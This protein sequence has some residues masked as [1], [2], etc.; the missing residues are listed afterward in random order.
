MHADGHPVLQQLLMAGQRAR[1]QTMV[2]ALRH[3]GIGRRALLAA[4]AALSIGL[5]QRSTRTAVAWRGPPS[6]TLLVRGETTLTGEAMAWRVVRDVAE[7]HAEAGFERRALG[8]AVATSNFTPLLLTD[9]ATGSASRLAWG[10]AAFV[11]DGTFQRRESLGNGADAY[12]RIGLFAAASSTD[13][14]GDRLLFAGPAFETPAGPVLLVLFRVDLEPGAAFPLPPSAGE[15]LVL[16]EQGEAELEV[17]GLPRGTRSLP[18]SA[19]TR[20]TPFAPWDLPPRYSASAMARRSWWQ[21]LS[22]EP[23]E[24]F[25]AKRPIVA[26]VRVEVGQ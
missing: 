16:V 25:N 21:P 8:F 11:R 5:V 10:E 13:S 20:R 3:S 6:P 2:A 26:D 24:R 15:T 19:A 1:R 14:G 17:G 4:S 12:L 22:D 9:Q 18:S 7:T 23:N